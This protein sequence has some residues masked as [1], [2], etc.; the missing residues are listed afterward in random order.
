MTHLNEILKMEDKVKKEY[1]MKLFRMDLLL[2]K[3]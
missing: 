3:V 1:F 2:Q